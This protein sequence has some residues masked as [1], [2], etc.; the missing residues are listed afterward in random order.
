MEQC[1][2]KRNDELVK[3]WSL[4][5]LLLLLPAFLAAEVAEGK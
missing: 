5:L 4:L 2:V 3:S 1:T